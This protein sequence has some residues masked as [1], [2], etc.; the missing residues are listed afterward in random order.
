MNSNEKSTINIAHNPMSHD[1]TKHMEV[2]RHFIKEKHENE[3]ICTPYI[4]TEGQLIDI[5]TKG[6]LLGLFKLS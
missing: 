2:D 3:L 4:H 6:F 5:L 1:Q